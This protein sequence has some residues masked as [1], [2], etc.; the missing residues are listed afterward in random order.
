MQTLVYLGENKAKTHFLVT[1]LMIR[2]FEFKGNGGENYE[3]S[4]Y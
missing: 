4:G 2:H 1:P 3:E